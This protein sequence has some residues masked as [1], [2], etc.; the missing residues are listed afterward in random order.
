M[1]KNKALKATT[2]AIAVQR[3]EAA[4]GLGGINLIGA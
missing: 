1:R 3:P 2:E 4:K